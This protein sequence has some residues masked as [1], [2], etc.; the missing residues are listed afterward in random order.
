MKPGVSLTQAVVS[1]ASVSR[2]YAGRLTPHCCAM[3][4]QHRHV[5]TVCSTQ[6]ALVTISQSLARPFNIRLI[7][8]F[9]CDV[10]FFA[11]LVASTTYVPIQQ[12]LPRTC[13]KRTLCSLITLGLL[14]LVQLLVIYDQHYDGIL[15]ASK[16]SK[17]GAGHLFLYRYLPTILAVTYAFI[18]HW[19]DVDTRRIEPYR[20]LS[21]PGGATGSNSLL[22]H[23]PTDLLAFVPL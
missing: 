20:Q 16:I 21:K 22:L 7:I 18:W 5:S 17:I 11:Y 23:Y 4:L 13:H 19:I 12:L 6:M 2:K 15:F 14:A 10:A 1:A 3:N 8:P 9:T